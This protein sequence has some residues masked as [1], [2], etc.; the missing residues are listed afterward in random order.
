[1]NKDKLFC[2]IFWILSFALVI[3]LSVF[4][5]FGSMEVKEISILVSLVLAVGICFFGGKK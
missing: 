2:E 5:I 4:L 3:S 1:M